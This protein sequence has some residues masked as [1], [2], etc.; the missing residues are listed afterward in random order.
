MN[1]KQTW[2]YSLYS[3][4]NSKLS[5]TQ[6]WM[7]LNSSCYSLKCVWCQ[8]TWLPST[9]KEQDPPPYPGFIFFLSLQLS[10]VK[11]TEGV[12]C[13]DFGLPFLLTGI[14]GLRI[15]STCRKLTIAVLPDTTW[16]QFLLS[17]TPSVLSQCC[18]NNENFSANW[19]TG[20]L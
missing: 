3:R 8:L 15:F 19:P 6:V 18:K 1:A 2:A 16:Q 13:K 5:N 20:K 9:A 12:L 10:L 4:K 17:F 14:R 7:H 11:Q